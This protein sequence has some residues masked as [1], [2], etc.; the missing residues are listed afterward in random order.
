[1]PRPS[2][3]RAR[4]RRVMMGRVFQLNR[5]AGGVP[6]LPIREAEVDLLGLDGDVQKHTKIHGG[7]ERALCLF[8]VEVIQRLQAEG[9]AIWPGSTGENVTVS[10]IPWEMLAP[11]MRLALGEHVVVELTRATEPCKQIA[12]S[13]AGGE[14][15]RIDVRQHPG[16]SRFYARVLRAGRV[17]V[18]DVVSV[19]PA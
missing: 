17:R 12:A 3:S 19:G 14:F 5:S 18:G 6:K 10:G 2:R 11:G 15:R 9:H 16:E 4:D 13:F 8:S 7:P 1:M